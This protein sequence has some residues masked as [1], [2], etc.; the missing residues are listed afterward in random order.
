MLRPESEAW[1]THEDKDR[2]EDWSLAL[3]ISTSGERTFLG[4]GA[5]LGGLSP[6][7]QGAGAGL[8]LGGGVMHFRV[9]LSMMAVTRVL[10]EFLLRNDGAWSGLELGLGAARDSEREGLVKCAEARWEH[11]VVDRDMPRPEILAPPPVT[12]DL[13][14]KH[15]QILFPFVEVLCFSVKWCFGTT[16]SQPI[17]FFGEIFKPSIYIPRH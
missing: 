9:E 16:N 17:T 10:I 3:S 5:V 2:L 7:S 8:R 6:G 14:R 11:A 15:N 13:K 12:G 1:L 4:R